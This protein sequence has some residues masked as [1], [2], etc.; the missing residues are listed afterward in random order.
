[1]VGCG[2]RRSRIIAY[3]NQLSEVVSDTVEPMAHPVPVHDVYREDIVEKNTSTEALLAEAPER[4]GNFYK[5]Q[6]IIE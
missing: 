2:W 5:I 6:K 4:E 3:I 1:M